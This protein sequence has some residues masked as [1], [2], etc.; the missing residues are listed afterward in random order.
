MGAKHAKRIVEAL[1][2]D[3]DSI[4]AKADVQR[5]MYTAFFDEGASDIMRDARQLYVRLM[6]NNTIPTLMKEKDYDG[7]AVA[8]AII[9]I[10]IERR[11]S[12]G[13]R[14]AYRSIK[15]L[16]HTV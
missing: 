10:A 12:L 2:D 11:G 4:D 16:D 7:A 9:Q 6:K 14:N 1:L 5:Y 3:A 8:Q 15:R 13:G